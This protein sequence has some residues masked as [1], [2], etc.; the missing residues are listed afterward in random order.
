[1]LIDSAATSDSIP[2]GRGTPP[3]STATTTSA[4]TTPPSSTY[5]QTTPFYSSSS[6]SHSTASSTGTAATSTGTLEGS[7]AP[8]PP[9]RRTNTSSILWGVI[10]GL[11]VVLPFL[12]VLLWVY[13]RRRKRKVAASSRLSSSGF[14]DK[15][16]GLTPYISSSNLVLNATDFWDPPPPFT[17]GLYSAADQRAKIPELDIDYRS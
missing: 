13:L 2:P 1:M 6:L 7:I 15:H 5:T 3:T 4:T 16:I 8:S 17:P 14:M 12:A 9:L 11:G 10:G